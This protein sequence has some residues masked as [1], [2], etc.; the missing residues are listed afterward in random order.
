LNEAVGRSGAAR[1][2]PVSAST[3]RRYLNLHPRA[4]SPILAKKTLCGFL[5][6]IETSL[7]KGVRFA[8]NMHL[9][10]AIA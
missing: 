7:V 10:V 4:K 5:E 8:K 6:K 3:W 2:T 9:L 1:E